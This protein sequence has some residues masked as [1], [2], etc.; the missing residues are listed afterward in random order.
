M[1]LTGGNT[2]RPLPAVQRLALLE[3]V[4]SQLLAAARAAVAAERRGEPDPVAHLRYLLAETGQ[5]PPAGARPSHLL[6]GTATP[7]PVFERTFSSRPETIAQVRRFVA[8]VLTGWPRVYDAQLCASELATNALMHTASGQAGGQFTVRI[9]VCGQVCVRLE[10][11]DQ[12]AHTRSVTARGVHTSAHEQSVTT[13]APHIPEQKDSA[14]D[15]PAGEGGLGLGIVRALVGDQPGDGGL[16]WQHTPDGSVVS[17]LLTWA[18]PPV[19]A[20]DR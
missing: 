19:E 15:R 6:A 14:L 5:L 16:S 17:C 1:T 4:H 20:A 8:G 13:H 2:A 7:S 18:A 10:V 11:T 9:Q 12:G 3:A